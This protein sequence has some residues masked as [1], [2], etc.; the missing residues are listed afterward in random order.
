MCGRTRWLYSVDKITVAPRC[1]MCWREAL[2]SG[3]ISEKIYKKIR[4]HAMDRE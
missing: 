1:F 4:E 2:N 3:L